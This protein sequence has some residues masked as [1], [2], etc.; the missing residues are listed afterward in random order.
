[1]YIHK[2]D[3]CGK[4]HNYQIPITDFKCNY[5][6]NKTF[7]L[8]K[9]YQREEGCQ[10]I[11]R[12]LTIELEDETS[13]PKVFYKG[14]EVTNRIEVKLHWKTQKVHP[15]TGGMEYHIEYAD[16]EKQTIQVKRARNGEFL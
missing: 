7:H 11:D 8:L 15:G 9:D 3:K 5:C 4:E 10:R 16:K 6:N 2:C 12:L 1:M 14:Q 13:I